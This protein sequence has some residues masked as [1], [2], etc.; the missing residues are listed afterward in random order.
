MYIFPIKIVF[1]YCF[2]FFFSILN[3]NVKFK[4]FVVAP[5]SLSRTNLNVHYL[6][7]LLNKFHLFRRNCFRKDFQISS[8]SIPVLLSPVVTILPLGIGIQTKY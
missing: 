2:G 5:P 8:L 4:T 1:F 6:R 7:V 3:I